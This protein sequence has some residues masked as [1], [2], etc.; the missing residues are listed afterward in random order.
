MRNRLTKLFGRK[1]KDKLVSTPI[2]LEPTAIIIDASN[3][4]KNDIQP[5]DHQPELHSERQNLELAKDPHYQQK[6]DAIGYSIEVLD[7]FKELSE[8]LAL[9]LPNALGIALKSITAILERL[10]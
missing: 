3:A 8:V 1:K 6:L 2:G 7:L 5:N 10:K 4:P 9:V